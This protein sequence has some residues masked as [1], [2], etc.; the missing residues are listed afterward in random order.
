MS[1][2]TT[3]SGLRARVASGPQINLGWYAS[4]D[5]VKVVGYRI[6]RNNSLIKRVSGTRYYDRSI[7]AG[8]TYYYYVRAYDAAGN[9]SGRSSVVRVT[10]PGTGAPRKTGDLNV[11]GRVNIFDL[12]ILLTRWKSTN[13]TADINNSGRVDIF[14]LSILLS[15]WGR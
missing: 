7:R 5:N 3:P 1:R 2:P 8:R 6:Y 9:V 13:N 11:D 15:R 14:D 10:T 4:S 12:S